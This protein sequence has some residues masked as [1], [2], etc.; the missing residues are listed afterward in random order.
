MQLTT[1][2]WGLGKLLLLVGALAATFLVFAAVAMRIA[3]RA[4]EVQVPTLVGHTVNDAS[5]SLASLGWRSGSIPTSARNERVP[6][7]R[8]MQQDPPPGA[9]ARRQRTIRVWV[10]SGPRTTSGAAAGRPDRAHARMRIEQDGLEVGSV[11]EFRS[12][13]YPA[14]AV[15]AQD[16]RPPRARRA[17]RCCS[18]AAS[19]PPRT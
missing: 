10:S 6:P 3:L 1:R 11:T 15:V 4:R 16:P 17:C 18:T 13:D 5:K 9:A 2:V 8:I 7:G 14:D 12:P 19:R